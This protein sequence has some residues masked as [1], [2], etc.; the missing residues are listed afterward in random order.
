[1]KGCSII[2]NYDSAEVRQM[3]LSVISVKTWAEKFLSRFG[4]KLDT[5]D[6]YAGLFIN[7]EMVGGGGYEGNIIKC[8]AIDPEVRGMGLANILITHLLSR[9]RADSVQNV[10]AFT[11]PD[12]KVIFES[13]SFHTIGESVEA[14]LLESKRHGISDFIKQ[15]KKSNGVNGAIVMNCNPFTSGHQY[16]AEQAASECDHLYLFVVKEDKSLFPFDVRINL[17][18]KCTGYL[19]NVIV[20]DGGPYIISSATFPSYFIKEYSYITKAYTELDIDI[21]AH[22][23][24]PALNIKKRFAGEEP[25]DCVTAEY[26]ES[27]RMI[28]P[29]YGILPVIIPRKTAGRMPVSAN[30]VR[31]L[32][33]ENRIND[34]K[35][36]VPSY[37]YDYI[38][39]NKAWLVQ[40]AVQRQLHSKAI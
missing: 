25:L 40:K 19:K 28:L 33:G 34:I 17:A 20:C 1:M 8:V 13:L 16:L 22:H 29:Q 12:N 7:D 3:P 14:I 9:L 31:H 6:Y 30:Y 37:T 27:M 10:F 24:A 5:L 15:L 39:C 11:K 36:L 26:N 32:I 4:L 23:I 18:R 21:F 2:M 35:E 38:V